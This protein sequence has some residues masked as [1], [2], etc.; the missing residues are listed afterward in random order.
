MIEMSCSGGR[1]DET[2]ILTMSPFRETNNQGL[3]VRPTTLNRYSI[4][5]CCN[6]ALP[7]HWIIYVKGDSIFDNDVHKFF[8]PHRVSISPSSLLLLLITYINKSFVCF[9]NP[10]LLFELLLMT[11]LINI[12]WVYRF[13]GNNSHFPRCSSITILL[14]FEGGKRRKE[15]VV[16][17]CEI[18]ISPI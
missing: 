3:H 9:S 14:W 17:F 18:M 12:K 13:S 2:S 1:H 11:N 6:W 4:L 15:G 8:S 10:I 16:K 5:L 7:C